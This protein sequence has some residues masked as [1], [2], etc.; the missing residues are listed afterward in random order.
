MTT[1]LP[2]RSHRR[3]VRASK[4]HDDNVVSTELP[5]PPRS[6]IVSPGSMTI[7]EPE[8]EANG[9]MPAVD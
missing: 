8:A 2:R 9:D 3:A 5:Q 1:M 7:P 6:A 4:W